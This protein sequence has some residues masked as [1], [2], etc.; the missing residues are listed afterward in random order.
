MTKVTDHGVQKPMFFLFLA[1]AIVISSCARK[2]ATGPF[3]ARVNDQYLSTEKVKSA[4]DTSVV[5]AQPQVRDYVT[6]WVNSA[7]LYE[8]AKAQGLDRSPEVNETMEELRRQLAVNRLLETEVYR[9][10]SLQV[11]DVELSDYY[12]QHKSDYV[13][14]EDMAKIRYVL[15]TQREA[16]G[17]FRTELLKGKPWMDVLQTLKEDSSFASAVITRADSQYMKKSTAASAELWRAITQLNVGDPPTIVKDEVGYFVLALLGLQRVGE[18]APL[19]AVAEATRDRVLIQKRQ[20]SL[21]QLLERLRG[22]YSV[23]VNLGALEIVD[24]TKTEK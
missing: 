4:F 1:S 8:E 15:F 10:E 7:L 16:A 14:V 22:K 19:P 20:Q 13:L 24:T 3:V 18:T 12:E 17:R 11:T 5:A 21:S 6:H 2:T 9:D 23:Q